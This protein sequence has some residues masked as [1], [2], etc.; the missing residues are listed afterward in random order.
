[1]LDPMPISMTGFNKLKEELHHLEKDEMPEV[2]RR[3]AEAREHGDLKENGE[4]I[5]G[6]ERLGFLMGRT[7]ELKGMINRSD[8]VDCTKVETE[9]AAFGT[10]VTLLDLDTQKQV[11]YQ[12]LGPD[13]A[14]TDTGSISI[15][16]PIG[17]AI[18][19]AVVGDQVEVETPRGDRHFEVI[20][21]AKSNIP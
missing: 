7:S 9:D 10:V 17:R 19:G 15:Q 18:L 11:T 1:M 6:R 2:M 12:L 5:A 21:I 20:A 16:S 14:D 3:V 4:Y 8:P 13:E